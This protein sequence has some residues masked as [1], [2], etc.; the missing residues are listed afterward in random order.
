MLMQDSIQR[1]AKVHCHTAHV[2]LTVTKNVQHK[3]FTGCETQ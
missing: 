1:N 2:Q 3:H